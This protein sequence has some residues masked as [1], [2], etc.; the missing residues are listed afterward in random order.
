M[1]RA[2]ERIRQEFNSGVSLNNRMTKYGVR[3]QNLL[4]PP[5]HKEVTPYWNKDLAKFSKGSKIRR[6]GLASL[7]GRSSIPLWK[8]MPAYSNHAPANS[9]RIGKIAFIGELRG[10]AAASGA[11]S[12]ESAAASGAVTKAEIV[13]GEDRCRKSDLV[14]IDSLLRF[15]E[16]IVEESFVVHVLYIVAFGKPVTTSECLA[17]C[18]GNPKRLTTLETQNAHL[19][20][21]TFSF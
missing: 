15:H 2:S 13:S 16:S 19:Y 7:N 11:Q 9:S 18:G 21:F 5:V 17:Q 14:V 1:L 10:S 12:G 8:N 20:F 6:Q 4:A 3:F